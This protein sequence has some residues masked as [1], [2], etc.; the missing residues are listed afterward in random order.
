MS[1]ANDTD[2]SAHVAGNFFGAA[3]TSH[4]P[5]YRPGIPAGG[6]D[7]WGTDNAAPPVERGT[8]SSGPALR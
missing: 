3:V 8:P 5:Q 4:S 6:M 7:Q 2:L 1:L